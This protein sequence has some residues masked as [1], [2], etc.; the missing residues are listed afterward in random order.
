MAT[1]DGPAFLRSVL[2]EGHE[3]IRRPRTASALDQCP[4]AVTDCGNRLFGVDKV[5]APA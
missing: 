4:R 3:V 5:D 1:F 2:S